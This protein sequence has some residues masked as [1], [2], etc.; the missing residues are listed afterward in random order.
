M[1]EFISHSEIEKMS[2][3][4][5]EIKFTQ[6]FNALARRQRMLLQTAHLIE[7]LNC[8]QTALYYRR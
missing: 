1:I 8:I 6:L 3:T 4:E 2:A 5:L 7:A